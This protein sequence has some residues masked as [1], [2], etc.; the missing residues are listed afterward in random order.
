MR[1]ESAQ[2][3]TG[4]HKGQALRWRRQSPNCLTSIAYIN[5]VYLQLQTLRSWGYVEISPISKRLA[6]NVVGMGAMAEPTAIVDHIEKLL[7]ESPEENS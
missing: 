2:N 4:Y 6:C 1:L 5:F 7:N 3:A